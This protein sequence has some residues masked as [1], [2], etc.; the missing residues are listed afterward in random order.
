[1]GCGFVGTA[2][3]DLFHAREWTVT[4]WTHSAESAGR[5]NA[6]KPYAVVAHDITDADAVRAA[7]ARLSGDSAPDVVIDCVS[8]GRGG[9]E[10]YRRVYLEGAQHLLDAFRSARLIF[11]GST[12]V[13]A[14]TNGTWVDEASP[15][16]PDR[17]PGASCVKRKR[18]CSR[19]PAARSRAWPE[20]T[21]RAARRR[22]AKS[23]RARQ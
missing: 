6:E 13:Y 4:A 21:G 22:C 23:S 17:K 16:S 1:M 3:A 18:S 20:F 2:A 12:S 15:A 7:A 14:Q 5:L 11:T 19:R 9:A 10:Q 8:S